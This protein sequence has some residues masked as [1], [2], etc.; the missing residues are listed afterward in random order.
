MTSWNWIAVQKKL[1]TQ[2]F[3]EKKFW[4]RFQG[5]KNDFE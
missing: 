3:F 4:Y 2:K 1:K 5:V